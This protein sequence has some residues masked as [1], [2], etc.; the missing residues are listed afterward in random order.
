MSV[1]I[2]VELSNNG[3]IPLSLIARN[4]PPGISTLL[5]RAISVNGCGTHLAV[6]VG[7]RGGIGRRIL[8]GS[9]PM[10]ELIVEQYTDKATLR[11]VST[12][13]GELARVLRERRIH[14]PANLAE[15]LSRVFDSMDYVSVLITVNGRR[16]MGNYY[17]LLTKVL[18]FGRDLSPDLV[19]EIDSIDVLRYLW[20]VKPK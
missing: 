1:G 14:G 6:K 19:S 16:V 3:S 18:E 2:F 5:K 17:E 7:E 20:M 15:H 12:L 9:P 8:L 11:R 4:T 13:M 10:V